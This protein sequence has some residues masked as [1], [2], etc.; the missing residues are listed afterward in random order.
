MVLQSCTYDPVQIP[1]TG[2]SLIVFLTTK[3]LPFQVDTVLMGKVSWEVNSKPPGPDSTRK[4]DSQ[5]A[6]DRRDFHGFQGGLDRRVL[7]VVLA[8][9]MAAATE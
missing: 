2:K 6:L 9:V 4:P 7:V 5:V 8:A 1:D 3:L